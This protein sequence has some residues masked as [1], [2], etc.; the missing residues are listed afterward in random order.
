M[1]WSQLLKEKG[2]EW[3]R[4]HCYREGRGLMLN[5]VQLIAEYCCLVFTLL[6]M[7][8]LSI[9]FGPKNNSGERQQFI[10]L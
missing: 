5:E 2:L 1:A 10:Q 7:T 8:F 6:Y 3:N 9:H 4:I